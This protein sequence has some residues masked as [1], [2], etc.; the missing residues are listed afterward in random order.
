MTFYFPN[1]LVSASD[2]YEWFSLTLTFLKEWSHTCELHVFTLVRPYWFWTVQLP[3]VESRVPADRHKTSIVLEPCNLTDKTVM[4]FKHIIDR[5]LSR[6]EFEHTNVVIVLACKQVTPIRE[7][8][9]T[10]VLNVA[11]VFIW[12]HFL[13]KDVHQAN[14]IRKTRYYV[15]T[16]WVKCNTECFVV[17]RLID[18]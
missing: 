17:K 6:I 3:E 8:N 13:A 10:A 12:Y 2:I 11:D 15:E 4:L 18:L 5:V 16:R 14:S 1:W 7:H 9:L